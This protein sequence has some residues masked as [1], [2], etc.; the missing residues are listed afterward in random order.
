[1]NYRVKLR[2][3]YIS[4]E[5]LANDIAQIVNIS[6]DN[7]ILAKI[8][9]DACELLF[10]VN[11]EY[12]KQIIIENIG[13]DISNIDTFKL[14]DITKKLLR[15]GYYNLVPKE[16]IIEKIK[17]IDFKEAFC[18]SLFKKLEYTE[19][20]LYHITFF[21][22]KCRVGN[23]FDVLEFYEFGDLKKRYEKFN[24]KRNEKAVP[25]FSNIIKYMIMNS[26]SGTERVYFKNKNECAKFYS[27][28]R[29]YKYGKI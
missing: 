9:N 20:H 26:N 18:E 23:L 15:A 24:Y 1:M 4:M 16:I 25:E 21:H 12:I 17:E 14:S 11:H 22:L 2:F 27:F 5:K 8:Y 19:Q 29:K 28:I 6:S 13:F 7:K 3:Y 10:Y